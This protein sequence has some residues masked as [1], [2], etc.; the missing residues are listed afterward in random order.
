MITTEE[1]YKKLLKK[2][3]VWCIRTAKI[4]VID[5]EEAIEVEGYTDGNF[6]PIWTLDQLVN[7]FK[8][9]QGIIFGKSEDKNVKN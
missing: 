3:F 8:E 7:K 9:E 6:I 1:E 5:A 4:D 2:F